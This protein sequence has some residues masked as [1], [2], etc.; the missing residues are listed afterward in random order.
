[1]AFQK[2]CIGATIA[3]RKRGREGGGEWKGDM[4][5]R[6]GEGRQVKQRESESVWGGGGE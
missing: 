5:V 3:C 6:E 1:M 2:P 4:R